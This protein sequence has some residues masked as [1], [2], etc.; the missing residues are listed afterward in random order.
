MP[1]AQPLRFVARIKPGATAT[2]TASLRGLLEL[3]FP[4]GQCRTS[5]SG[6]SRRRTISESEPHAGGQPGLPVPV[7]AVLSG[8]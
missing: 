1:S 4:L 8:Y 5:E 7:E 3:R 2:K 6:P